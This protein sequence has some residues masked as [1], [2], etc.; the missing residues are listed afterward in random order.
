MSGNLVIFGAYTKCNAM[1]NYL[2]IP[3]LFLLSCSSCKKDAV[4]P[5][6][7]LIGTWVS[8]DPILQFPIENTEGKGKAIQFLQYEK[9][10]TKY[11]RVTYPKGEDIYQVYWIGKNEMVLIDEADSLKKHINF[12][13][14]PE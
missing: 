2:L 9:V 7:T 6:R 14:I 10:G 4:F 1:K 3:F 12:V 8:Q 5:E 13:R 11:L